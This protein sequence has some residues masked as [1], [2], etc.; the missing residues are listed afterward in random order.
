MPFADLGAVATG[1]AGHGGRPPDVILRWRLLAWT[2]F[3][4]CFSALSYALRFTTTTPDD[5]LYTWGAAVSGLV[6]YALI[7]GIVL[8]ISRPRSRQLLALRRPRSWSRAAGLGLAVI[9]GVL[10]LGS[11]LDQFL[12]PGR[13]QGLIPDSWEP[14]KAAPFVANF[15]VIAVVAPLVEETTFRGLGFS[16]L[17]PFGTWIAIALVGLAFGLAHGLVQ[18]LPL[19]VGIGA[20]LAYIRSRTDSVYPGMIVHGLFN[21]L[22][23]IVAV[24]A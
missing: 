6:Q 18:G 13:E 4:V 2:A 10:L 8:L 22:V 24:T 21:G 20:G 1:T 7:L 15:V 12:D 11:I 19:L 23:L 14:S 16:L 5:V 17:E 9:T 3:V